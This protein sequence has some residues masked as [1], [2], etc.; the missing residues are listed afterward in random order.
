MLAR[1]SMPPSLA[2]RPAVARCPRAAARV[3]A[4]TTVLALA[5]TARAQVPSDLFQDEIDLAGR[6]TLTVGSGARAFGMGGAFLA[7]ADDATAASWNPAGLSYLRVSELSVVGTYNKFNANSG[8]DSDELE[9]GT[10]DFA[11]FTFPVHIGGPA[12]SVQVNYQRAVSF[13]GSRHIERQNVAG[14][15]LSTGQG[16]GGYD[17]LA[18]GTGLKLMRNLRVGL[19]LNR[20]F[21]GYSV[22]LDKLIPGG[23]RQRRILGQ[24]FDL[25]GW[26]SNLGVIFS[27][28]EQLNVAGVFKTAFTGKVHLKKTRTDFY[29]DSETGQQTGSTRNQAESPDVRIDFPW[30]LGFGTS[31]RPRSQLTFSADFTTTNWSQARIRNYFT[32]RATPPPPL[33]QP[34]APVVYPSLLYPYVY[35]T[36]QN[37]T[38]EIRVGAEY[39]LIRGRLRIPL[40]VGY[41]N[42]KQINNASLDTPPRFNGFTIG[43]GIVLGRVLFDVAYLYESGEFFEATE[44]A[45][46]ESPTTATQET[47]RN[48][49][50]NQR[51]FASIIYRL[52]GS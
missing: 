50:R 47:V 36:S 41:F 17:V 44:I 42:D 18:L 37:D 2:A 26:N 5:R 34:P 33:D 22:S 48:S 4:L 27:P 51:F 15:R 32:I 6:Q 21:N 40:R 20:W 31:W 30:S 14:T 28:I 35:L 39:V 29:F 49:V 9:G 46:G 43:T 25:D 11:S 23:V 45:S 52:G 3:A 7:R 13:D 24:D 16:D 8:N 10:V 12:G 38:E 19:T 1:D